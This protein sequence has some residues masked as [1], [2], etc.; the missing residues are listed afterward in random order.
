MLSLHRCRTR[1]ALA[2]V[3]VCWAGAGHAQERLTASAAV[4]R[5][6]SQ[7]HV[8]AELEAGVAL[9]RSEVVSARL[10]G[11]PTLG[12]EREQARGGPVPA[13]ETSLVLSQPVE[14]GARRGA[15]IRAA[16]TGVEA[17]RAAMAHERIRL[18]GEVL[19][20]YYAASAAG[21]RRQAQDKFAAGLAALAEVAGKRQRAGDLSGYESRRIQQASAQALAHRAE[22]AAAE[23]AARTRLA[24]WIG[25]AALTA[26]LDDAI[27]APGVSADPAETPGTELALLA[28]QRTHAHAQRV[29]AGRLSLPATV[30]IGTKR[31]REAGLSDSAVILELE[32]P[33]PLFD[34]NQG[35]RLRAEAELQRIDAAYQR[36][37][38]HVRARRAA[39]A[40]QARQLAAST[41][42]MQATLVPEAA[43]LTEIARLS[44]AEGEL[45]L[46]GLLDAYAAEAGIID[47]ALAQEAR[48]LDALLELERLGGP[49]PA[50]PTPVAQP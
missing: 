37:L 23:Q 17:A 38:L 18:R 24:G 32:L 41:R 40:E 43:R 48:A 3:V 49:V 27:A 30:G 5:A 22:A 13:S 47:A 7:A 44:F 36:T 21:R 4:E 8:Q 14:L 10:R 50:H 11:N 9:A 31:T 45:D 34:R 2:L 25:P 35:E 16:E 29:A 33:L 20:E 26:S 28:A 46:V 19:R 12:M 1:R 42:Q 15:R 39:A 6:L